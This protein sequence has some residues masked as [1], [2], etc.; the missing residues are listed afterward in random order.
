EEG[1]KELARV[2]TKSGEELLAAPIISRGKIYVTTTKA[3]YCI[4]KKGVEP[5]A[6]PLPEAPGETAKADDPQIAH[7]Q[8]AP[9]E[10]MLAP[11]QSTPF[12]VR[13]Y[14][15]N[16]QFLKLVEAEFTVDGGGEVADGGKY[17]APEGNE[18]TAVKITAKS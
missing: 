14:N 15:K 12:Q 5:T 10:V 3:L 6:D 17:T 7:L 13:A 8:I 9:V 11:G 18:H 2:R 16:G 1:V 4:G